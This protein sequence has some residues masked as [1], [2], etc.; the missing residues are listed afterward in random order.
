MLLFLLD[1][2]QS[3]LSDSL[4][5]SAW[6]SPYLAKQIWWRWWWLPD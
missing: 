3:T 1:V 5:W 2:D 4:A 6:L